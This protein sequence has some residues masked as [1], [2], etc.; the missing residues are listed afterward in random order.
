M[1]VK[2][3]NYLSTDSPGLRYFALVVLWG[4]CSGTRFCVLRGQSPG[5]EAESQGPL[6]PGPT[7]LI[8]GTSSVPG[9]GG[10][11]LSFP[12]GTLALSLLQFFLSNVSKKVSRNERAGPLCHLLLLYAWEDRQTLLWCLVG[13]PMVWH[14]CKL[15]SWHGSLFFMSFYTNTLN[16]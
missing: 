14:L 3:T 9:P 2:G 1:K 10:F 12:S 13:L 5:E 11:V 16:K 15:K 7:W 8:Q 4:R 6:C